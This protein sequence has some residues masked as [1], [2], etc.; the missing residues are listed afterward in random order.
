MSI[1]SKVQQE[2]IKSNTF[3]LS[4]DVKMSLNMG[5]LV[6]IHIMET[7]PG[8]KIQMSTSQMLRFAPMLAP[9]MHQVTAYTHFFFVP[10]RIIWP[11][12]KEFIAGAEEPAGIPDYVFPYM[13]L[14]ENSKGSLGDY[15]G[16][17]TSIGFNPNLRVSAL[18]FYAYQKIYNE[19]Y[20]DQNLINKSPDEALDGNNSFIADARTMQRRAWQHDYFTSALPWTQKGAEAT[21]PLGSVTEANF[22]DPAHQFATGPGAQNL[23]ILETG[24]ANNAMP[25]Q[26]FAT[27]GVGNAPVELQVDATTIN[28][29]R[30]AFKLQEWLEKNARGGSRYIESILAHF[31]VKSSDARLQRPEFL[32][33]GATPITISEVLQTSAA[34]T[35]P[36]PQGNMAGHGISVGANNSFSYFCEEHGYIIGIMSVMPKTAYQQGIHKHWTKFDK[37]DYYWPSFAHLGEQPILL[38]E[39]YVDEAGAGT[40]EDVFGYTPRYSE[41]KYLNSRVAGELRDTLDFWHLGRK[42]LN[43]PAL[44]KLFVECYPDDRIFAVLDSE[45]L[46][47][48]IHHRISAS[49]KM[50][51]FGTPK[52]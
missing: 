23:A 15:L 21:I 24:P 48:H 12:W 51:Y 17:P 1:F 27:G 9:I 29:L 36:T 6:P 25:L 20:R 41:Y 11:H 46:Y 10:N 14:M 32:G 4:H 45:K 5:E 43:T 33:G 13:D 42:F 47:A 3:D 26:A 35:E 28:D 44:N 8:D 19:Y 30:N 50:P 34:A 39:L 38:K 49:R 7:V 22:I 2:K 52:L 37:F 18:P 31:G 16:I 40:N